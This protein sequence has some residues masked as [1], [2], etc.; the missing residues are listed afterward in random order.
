M[1]GTA[2]ADLLFDISLRLE[3]VLGR[4][5]VEGFHSAVLEEELSGQ[6]TSLHWFQYFSS[7]I[8]SRWSVE[9][10]QKGPFT[11]IVTHESGCVG[12]VL[13]GT[14]F[15]PTGRP[16]AAAHLGIELRPH[17]AVNPMGLGHISSPMTDNCDRRGLM[18]ST[19]RDVGLSYPGDDQVV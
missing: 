18:C 15:K 12:L 8:A 17:L 13:A 7:A 5:A 16:A 14:P 3:V 19:P 4:T 11:R 2:Y 9:T 10:L 1:G 6:L